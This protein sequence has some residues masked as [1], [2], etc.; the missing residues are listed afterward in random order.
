MTDD[1]RIF[2]ITMADIRRCP[3]HSIHP[4]HYNDDGSCRCIVDER[5]KR[6][7]AIVAMV[8]RAIEGP[9][10]APDDVLAQ[11]RLDPQ[12]ASSARPETGHAVPSG[13]PSHRHSSR[14]GGPLAP[15]LAVKLSDPMR[16]ELMGLARLASLRGPDA[17]RRI[18]LGTGQAL[19]RRGLAEVRLGTLSWQAR[20]TDRGLAWLTD[21]GITCR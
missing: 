6:D 12:N 15:V 2:T 14:P 1:P 19:E 18:A 4:S 10:L 11:A 21:R 13:M 9:G 5:T 7:R 16:N 3:K 20:I 8:D 17:W